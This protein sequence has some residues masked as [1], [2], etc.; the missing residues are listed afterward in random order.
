MTAVA[1]SNAIE[2]G[3]IAASGKV[4]AS[5]AKGNTTKQRTSSC[6]PERVT[7]RTSTIPFK[8]YNADNTDFAEYDYWNDKMENQDSYL[9]GYTTCDELFYGWI[10]NYSLEVDD[11]RPE[12][13]TEA[14]YVEGTFEINGLLMVKPVKIAGINAVLQQLAEESA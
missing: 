8:D 6:D 1:F 3:D 14:A 9:M 7:Q 13:S 5:K 4:L 10:S 11:P 2:A 12:T